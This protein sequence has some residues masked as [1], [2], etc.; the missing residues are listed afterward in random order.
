MSCRLPIW[1]WLAIAVAGLGCPFPGKAFAREPVRPG[2]G[3][4]PDLAGMTFV[5]IPAGSFLMGSNSPEAGSDERPTHRVV[6]RRDFYLS[7]TEVTQA[8]WKAVMG[9]NPSRFEGDDLPVENVSWHDCQEF[10]RKLNQRDPEKGYRLPTEAEWEYACRA[11]GPGE[12]GEDLASVAWY[13]PA[14]KMPG[15]CGETAADGRTHPAG[16]KQA[17]AWGLCDMLGNVYEWCLDWK[18]PYPGRSVTDPRGPSRGLCRVVRGGSWYVHANRTK[19]WFRDSFTPECRR[20]DIG[21]RIAA[22]A[23]AASTR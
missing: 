6:L 3:A 14:P 16:R 22:D 12:S 11:G 15:R 1:L 7:S 13:D 20:F 21:F 8:Q 18:G 4:G 5:R 9:G 23:V 10:L 17:N 19:A 2:R